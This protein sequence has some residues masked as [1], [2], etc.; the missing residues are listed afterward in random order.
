VADVG[1]DEAVVFLIG[2]H[3]HRWRRFRSWF[4][5]VAAMTRMLRQ[6]SKNP[7]VGLLAAHPYFS[8]RDVLVVQYWRSVEDLG[9]FAKDPAL[10][11]VPAWS[12]FNSA[13]A[14]SGDIGIW[15]E[16]YRV[17]ADH[18]ETRYANM[19]PFGLAKAIGMRER[20][21][22]ARNSTHQRMEETVPD[23]VD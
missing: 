19:A 17:S 5:T 3:V 9:R 7:D 20:M 4:P 8:G 11:H 15:H 13:A 2:A 10:A 12:E 6:L 22:S 14:G 1:D 21:G 18:I 23:H 16:T